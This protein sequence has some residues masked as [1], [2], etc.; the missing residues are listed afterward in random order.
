M[1][2]GVLRGAGAARVLHPALHH[3]RD[4]LA[5][6]GPLGAANGEAVP[7][8]LPAGRSSGGR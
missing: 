2:R 1:P 7:A 4:R 6:A 5:A 8:W 3:R